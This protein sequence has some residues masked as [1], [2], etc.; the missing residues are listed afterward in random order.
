[1]DISILIKYFPK[2]FEKG[3]VLLTAYVAENAALPYHKNN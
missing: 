3:H 1:M 2:L